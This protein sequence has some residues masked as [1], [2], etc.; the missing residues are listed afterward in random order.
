MGLLKPLFKLE[1]ELQSKALGALLS[2]EEKESVLSELIKNKKENKALVYTYGLSP[3]STEAVSLLEQSGYEYTEI[4]LGAEWFTL[5]PKP[6]L[7]RTELAKEVENGA[8]SLPK[9]FI[10]GKCIGGCAELSELVNNGELESVLKSAKV[11]KKGE[12]ANTNPL[13]SFFQK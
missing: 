1:A 9:V 8:T 11:P 3:F 12:K 13:L 4:E 7:I 2:D 6:S 5:G 10:G